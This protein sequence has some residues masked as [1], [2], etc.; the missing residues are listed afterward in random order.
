LKN[1]EVARD[2]AESRQGPQDRNIGP[3]RVRLS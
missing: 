1:H 3:A 2:S